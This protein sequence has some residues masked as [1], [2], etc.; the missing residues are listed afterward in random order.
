[1]PVPMGPYEQYLMTQGQQQPQ[2]PDWL[3]QMQ[4]QQAGATGMQGRGM[5]QPTLAPM[6]TPNFQ[7]TGL[8]PPISGG[9]DPAQ[10]L[11]GGANFAAPPMQETR[12]IQVAPWMAD[13]WNMLLQIVSGGNE[14]PP[15]MQG[16]GGMPGGGAMFGM[17]GGSGLGGG[18]LPGGMAPMPTPTWSQGWK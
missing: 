17:P 8:G 11:G 16:S 10:G 1:M 9:M 2:I 4:Q 14:A 3:R 12:T 13:L 15:Q 5:Q 6:P 7:A 18:T